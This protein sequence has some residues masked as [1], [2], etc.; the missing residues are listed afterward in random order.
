MKSGIG[1]SRPMSPLGSKSL[2]PGTTPACV[3][4]KALRTSSSFSCPSLQRSSK[5]WWRRNDFRANW[6]KKRWVESRPITRT[7]KGIYIYEKEKN[8]LNHQNQLARW[9]SWGYAPVE[10]SHFDIENCKLRNGRPT[11]SSVS[12]LSANINGSSLGS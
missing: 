3:S 4:R 6:A 10:G 8:G 2:V 12:G 11:M 1:K 7:Y 9:A 5:P